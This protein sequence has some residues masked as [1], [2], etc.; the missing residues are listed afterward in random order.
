MYRI[1]KTEPAETCRSIPRTYSF[2]YSILV[3]GRIPSPV[4][5]LNDGLPN[6]A[7]ADLPGRPFNVCAESGT[8]MTALV[9]SRTALPDASAFGVKK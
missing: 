3:P 8:G 2:S 9:A 1:L 7:V 4:D 5:E 6:L